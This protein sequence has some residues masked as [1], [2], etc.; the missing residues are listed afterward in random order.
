MPMLFHCHR[1]D[2][3]TPNKDGVCSS[4]KEKKGVPSERLRNNKLGDCIPIYRKLDDTSL[5]T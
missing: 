1:C 4:C 3:P 5:T 2:K